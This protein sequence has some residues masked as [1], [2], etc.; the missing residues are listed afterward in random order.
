MG[1]LKNVFRSG[2]KGAWGQIRIKKLSE[3]H[4]GGNIFDPVQQ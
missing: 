1:S 2:R 4:N 3:I